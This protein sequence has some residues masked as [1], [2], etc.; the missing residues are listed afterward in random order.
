[1]QKMI[2]DV[3]RSVSHKEPAKDGNK[4]FPSQKRKTK[5]GEGMKEGEEDEREN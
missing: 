2:K 4:Q 5:E 1:M 3:K